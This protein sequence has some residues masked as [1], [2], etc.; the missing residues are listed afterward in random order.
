MCILHCESSIFLQSCLTIVSW[1]VR[2]EASQ[3]S[4]V[5][6]AIYSLKVNS[7]HSEESQIVLLSLSHPSQDVRSYFGFETCLLHI[8]SLIRRSSTSETMCYVVYMRSR[9]C[10]TMGLN[11]DVLDSR[12]HSCTKG[13]FRKRR[14]VL[15]LLE[16]TSP[17]F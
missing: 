15:H 10:D 7:G 16:F 9:S 4:G 14:C 12:S 1:M 8:C 5:D 3:S 2:I 13:F 11:N 17:K 6:A